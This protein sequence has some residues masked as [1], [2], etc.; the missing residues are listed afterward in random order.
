MATIKD[1]FYEG[2]FRRANTPGNFDEFEK[3]STGQRALKAAKGFQFFRDSGVLIGW[4]HDLVEKGEQTMNVSRRAKGLIGSGWRCIGRES[5]EE[6]LEVGIWLWK[7]SAIKK[8]GAE[9]RR[10]R[11]DAFDFQGV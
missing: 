1:D 4:F 10:G 7:P 3:D 5:W 11:T 9:R 6:L 8:R 2:K